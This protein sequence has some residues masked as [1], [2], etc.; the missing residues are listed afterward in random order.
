MLVNH[1]A[2]RRGMGPG[3]QFSEV[4]VMG[5]E[6]CGMLVREVFT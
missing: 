3:Y 2:V 1:E 4:D 5:A 6:T